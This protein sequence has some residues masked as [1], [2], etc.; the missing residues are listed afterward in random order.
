M[1]TSSSPSSSV[2]RSLAERASLMRHAPT[3]SEARLF[4][5]LRGGRLGVSFRRQVPVLG[6]FIADLLAPE[7]RLVV[8]VDGLCHARRGAADARRDRALGRAG[9]T[10]LRVEAGL[11]MGDL[12]AAVA[13]VAR[14]VARLRGE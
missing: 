11:V 7:V 3:A 10:V 6:R 4:E 12:E 9:Y 1:P 2:A 14:E 5:A 8:E 13:C